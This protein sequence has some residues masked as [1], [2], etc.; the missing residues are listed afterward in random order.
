MTTR[1]VPLKSDGVVK[2]QI[3]DTAGQER[4]QA[5]TAAHY[6]RSRGAIIVYDITKA[7]TFQN[8][9]KCITALKAN[10]GEDII[11]MLVGN[12]L[13]LVTGNPKERKVLKNIAKNF[14]Y[15]NGLLFDESSAVS[16]NNVK[17]PF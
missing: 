8:V 10:A 7:S 1:S 17:E 9:K 14:A 11:I 12:K 3:W 5:I 2:A 6:K 16:H 15:V 4:Y 13:D